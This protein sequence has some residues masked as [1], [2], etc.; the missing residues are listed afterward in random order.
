MP[1]TLAQL[2]AA[3]TTDCVALLGGIYEHSPWVAH[4]AA[5]QRP[6]KSLTHL[7]YALSQAVRA[8]GREA[9]VTLIRAHP[10]LAGKAMVAG[11]LTA[12]STGEQARAG[13]T[14]CTPEEFATLKQLNDAYNAKFGW[15]FIVAVR[16]DRGVGLTRQQIIA[17]FSRR[18]AGSPA[19]ELAECL[20]NIDRIAEIRLNERFDYEPTVGNQ[21]YDWCETLAQFSDAQDGA[22]TVTYLTPRLRGAAG[23]ANARLRF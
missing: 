12:E 8:A 10:E 4:S 17:T 5:A 14:H 19:F 11:T 1:L 6:F 16:G 15:P 22:L 21:I 9:Q 20:R 18:L 13:L 2:N 7:K 23:A 3:S